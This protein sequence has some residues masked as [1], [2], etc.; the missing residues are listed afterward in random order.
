M[1]QQNMT[2]TLKKKK[3][4]SFAV[5]NVSISVSFVTR[6]SCLSTAAA[7]KEQTY[8]CTIDVYNRGHGSVVT[9]S[10][11]KS[12]DPG[13]DPLAG[14]SEEQFFCP[15]VNSCAHLFV[16]DPPLSVRHTPTF[17]RTFLPQAAFRH[18]LN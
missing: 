18:S 17:V 1:G 7:L 13:F 14:R 3:F 6:Q 5:A 8:F 10:E 11:F 2:F 15:S 4:W 16:P 9:E 12:K